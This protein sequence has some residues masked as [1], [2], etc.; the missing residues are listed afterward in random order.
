[1]G[2]PRDD[3]YATLLKLQDKL[4]SKGWHSVYAPSKYEVVLFDGVSDDPTAMLRMTSP[5]AVD[6]TLTVY[7]T[8][9]NATLRAVHDKLERPLDHLLELR[10]I[11]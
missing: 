10:T 1:M 11:K 5:G 2:K 8:N 9:L 7:P 3:A 4:T 6:V